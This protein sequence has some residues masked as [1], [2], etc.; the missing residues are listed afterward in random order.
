MNMKEIKDQREVGIKI[1]EVFL[2]KAKKFVSDGKKY[3][4]NNDPKQ[5]LEYFKKALQKKPGLL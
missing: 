4:R 5:D 2:I 3:L 1:S